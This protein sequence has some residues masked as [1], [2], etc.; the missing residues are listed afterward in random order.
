MW[1]AGQYEKF[2]GERSRPFFDLLSRIP[3]GSYKSIVDLGCGTGDLTA[4]LADHWPD[5]RVIGVD[6]SDEM[7]AAAGA[8]A[9]PG[10][11]DFVKDD[12]ATWRSAQPVELVVSNAAFHWV[13]DHDV[14][15]PRVA[16]FLG[17]K[18]LLAVQVPANF[19]SPSH[20]LMRETIAAGPWAGK[21][22]G[23]LHHDIVL[24]PSRYVEIGWSCGLR[25]DAWETIYQHVLPGKDAVLEWVKGTALRPVLKA[26]EGE[27]R[28]AFL[29]AYAARLQA[30]YPETPSGTIFPFRR[31]FFVARKA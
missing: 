11:L 13:P 21:L 3:D 28:D 16:E 18:G 6:N 8:H 5:A 30:A 2:R 14:L 29:S 10:R 27:E 20:L 1:D 23:R 7:L 12:I 9:D 4:V 26:L 31:V 19:E 25:V 22:A 15:I 24:P 17:K